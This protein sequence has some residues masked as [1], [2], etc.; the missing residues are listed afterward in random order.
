M[1]KNIV[2]VVQD[3][4]RESKYINSKARYL[5]VFIHVHT[6]LLLSLLSIYYWFPFKCNKP[7]DKHSIWFSI[8]LYALRSIN[9]WLSLNRGRTFNLRVQSCFGI[10][11]TFWKNQCSFSLL[12]HS[13]DDGNINICNN[14]K[15]SYSTTHDVCIDVRPGCIC[16]LG[17]RGAWGS[18]SFERVRSIAYK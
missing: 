9:N 15:Q 3:V 18:N 7:N 12:V 11:K 14:S 10:T 4:E 6:T 13:Y 5:N 16:G 2:K 1:N 8:T 17:V